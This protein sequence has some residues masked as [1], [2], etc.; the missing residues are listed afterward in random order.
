MAVMVWKFLFEAVV[1]LIFGSMVV[2]VFAGALGSGDGGYGLAVVM[3]FHV[4]WAVMAV[5]ISATS[6]V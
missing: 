2:R 4:V 1:V 6:V 3:A 5:V